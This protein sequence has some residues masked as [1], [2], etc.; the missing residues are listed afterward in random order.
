MINTV[1]LD[2]ITGFAGFLATNGHERDM[3]LP[4]NKAYVFFAEK[5]S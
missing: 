3:M 2:R 1:F 4:W 5:P